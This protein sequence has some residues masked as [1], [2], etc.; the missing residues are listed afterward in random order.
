MKCLLVFSRLSLGFEKIVGNY[1]ETP[2][3]EDFVFTSS[4]SFSSSELVDDVKKCD[5]RELQAI[6][7]KRIELRHE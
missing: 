7:T 2:P 6:G 4:S 5:V 1:Q 3:H